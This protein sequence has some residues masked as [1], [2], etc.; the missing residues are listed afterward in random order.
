MEK[1][2]KRARTCEALAIIV[3]TRAIFQA[4]GTWSQK[5]DGLAWDVK[6]NPIDWRIGNAVTYHP[7][8]AL[9]YVSLKLFGIT[10]YTLSKPE[11]L[12]EPYGVTN[13]ALYRTLNNEFGYESLLDWNDAPGRDRTDVV[14]LLSRT[15]EN[16]ITQLKDLQQEEL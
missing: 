11:T 16:L 3:E 12:D 6:G 10:D 14:R 8:A 1:T 7:I 4:S 15:Q 2:D 5:S 13:R 9:R